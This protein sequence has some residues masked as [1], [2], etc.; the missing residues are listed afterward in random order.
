MT[1]M[2]DRVMFLADQDTRSEGS[3]QEDIVDE[4]GPEQ[5][6]SDNQMKVFEDIFHVRAG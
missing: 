3:C 1:E 6:F 2:S 5:Y 4:A